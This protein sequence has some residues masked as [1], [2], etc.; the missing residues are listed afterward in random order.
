LVNIV[1]K[2]T[3][4]PELIQQ[5]ATPQAMADALSMLLED[6]PQRRKMLADYG[7][8]RQLLGS[9]DAAENTA[10]ILMQK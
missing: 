8:V 3:V 9:L 5:H 10:E 1:A 6:T 7:E 2:R 4:C